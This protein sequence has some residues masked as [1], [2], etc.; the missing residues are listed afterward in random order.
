MKKPFI[1]TSDSF[2]VGCVW[3]VRLVTPDDLYYTDLVHLFVS[4]GS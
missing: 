3:S 1:S 4:F 2:I